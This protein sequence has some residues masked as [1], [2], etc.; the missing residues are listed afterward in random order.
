M[1]P[2][3]FLAL[4]L[5]AGVFGSFVW[6]VRGHFTSA[7]TP[8]GMWVVSGV[9]AAGFGFYAVALF[10]RP[11]PSGLILCGMALQGAA[12]TL[13]VWAIRATRTKGLALAFDPCAPALLVQSGPYRYLRHPFYSSYLLF[14]GATIVQTRVIA[15]MICVAA[16]A[17]LYGIATVI[18]ERGYARSMLAAE[19]QS[20]KTRT[21]RFL[22]KLT[23]AQP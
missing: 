17:V 5:A 15:V 9:S 7:H 23:G 3:P 21:G 4:G 19:Y 18:E 6:A 14:W 11:H 2:V 22:P 20:Y 12:M 8:P 16:L 13:F 10:D 1:A